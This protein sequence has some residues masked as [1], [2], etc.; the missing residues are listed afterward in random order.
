[1]AVAPYAWT[2]FP[3]CNS[4][5]LSADHTASWSLHLALG[6]S[7]KANKQGNKET[8]VSSILCNYCPEHTPLLLSPLWEQGPH[9]HQSCCVNVGILATK[10]SFPD[11]VA[12]G[13]LAIRQC[14]P[15]KHRPLILG[16]WA[17]QQWRALLLGAQFGE[18]CPKAKTE[19]I[20]MI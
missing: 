5:P 19:C 9:L 10:T 17:A 3:Q 4:A 6:Q 11:G 15:L 13:A 7:E 14:R 8:L 2:T 18:H 12:I 1:M 20:G 16:C